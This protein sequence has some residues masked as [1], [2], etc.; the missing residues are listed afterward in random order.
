MHELLA[1]RMDY[2]EAEEQRSRWN[3]H[4]M[5]MAERRS[6]RQVAELNP[7]GTRIRGKPVNMGGD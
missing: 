7:Q 6:A 1:T 2:L 4:G 3:G 5:R